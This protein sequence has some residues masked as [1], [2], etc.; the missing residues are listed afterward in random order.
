MNTTLTNR[1]ALTPPRPR[2][3]RLLTL[4]S[5][6]SKTSSGATFLRRTPGDKARDAQVSK[7]PN[8]K[9][10]QQP[11]AP[12]ASAGVAVAS[13]TKASRTERQPHE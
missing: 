5:Q 12:V 7:Q 1:A 10:I 8:S 11:E 13:A 6:T 4:H 3:R 2:G 9:H